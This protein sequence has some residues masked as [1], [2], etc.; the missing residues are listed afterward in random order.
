VKHQ[1]GMLAWMALQPRH[2]Q[3]VDD[4]V[5]R[6]L[7]A[8]TLADYLTIEQVDHRGQ[9]QPTFVTGDVCDI[10]CPDR[11]WLCH[12]ELPLEQVWRYRKDV[13]AVGG[14]LESAFIFCT[15]AVQLHELLN[16]SLPM[17]MRLPSSSFQVRGQ[18]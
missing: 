17:R 8:Q 2:A 12:G 3:C 6:N 13:I 1:F 10:A 18:P 7:R 4:N 15:Y 5:A 11:V 14:D 9:E 16:T